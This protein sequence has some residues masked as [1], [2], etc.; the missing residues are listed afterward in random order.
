MTPSKEAL[1]AADAIAETLGIA[2][3]ILPKIID[4]A[5]A[6]HR[7][8]VA[9]LVAI[10]QRARYELADAGGWVS[11]AFEHGDRMTKRHYQR[12]IDEIHTQLDAALA[13]LKEHHEPV[14]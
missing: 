14:A 6:E 1:S 2:S 4:D 13:A 9:A 10:A 5:F 11:S 12:D 3:D 7:E 8:R